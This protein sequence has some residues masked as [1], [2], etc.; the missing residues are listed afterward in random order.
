[1]PLRRPRR[2]DGFSYLGFQRY[3][4]TFCTYERRRLFVSTRYVEAVLAQIR[5]TSEAE[6]FDLLA[7]CFMP[8]HLHLLEEG[9]TPTADMRRLVSLIRQRSAFVFRTRFH[10]PRLWQHGYFERVLRN[11]EATQAVIRY[12]FDNPVRAG[13][14]ERYQDYPYL[15]GKYSPDV[16]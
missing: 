15:G 14:V 9:A 12:L 4:L 8:D 1:M 13:I 16:L 7:Y 3:S 11:D 6:G 5:R 2:L 10:V